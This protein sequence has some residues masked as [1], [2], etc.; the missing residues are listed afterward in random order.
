MPFRSKPQFAGPDYL[1]AAAE[2]RKQDVPFAP[3]FEEMVMAAVIRQESPGVPI[4]ML[5][6]LAPGRDLEPHEQTAVTLMDEAMR[7]ALERRDN[8]S[9][10]E[11]ARFGTSMAMRFDE[12]LRYIRRLPQRVVATTP[13]FE[14]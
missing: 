3:E 11:L 7:R 5:P 4:S 13:T 2:E 10:R 14:E 8:E 6:G 12:H 9:I 1:I